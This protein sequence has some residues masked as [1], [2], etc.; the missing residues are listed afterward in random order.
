MTRTF[1]LLTGEYPPQSGGVGDYT[2]MVAAG[3][4]AR[5]HAVHV[6]SPSGG[7]PCDGVDVHRLPDAFGVRSRRMLGAALTSQPGT[8]LLQ[9]V[10]NALGV[11]G[12]NV[13][14]CAWLL[15]AR[16]RGVDVRVMFHEPY[17][18]FALRRPSRNLLAATQRVMAAL[19]LRASPVAYISTSAWVRYLRPWG[20][21]VLI[22]SPI[23]ATIPS[24]PV[25]A[26]VDRWRTMFMAGR[27]AARLV[28]HFGTFGD[29]MAAE[30]AAALP[31]VLAAAPDVSFVL[32]GR[33]AGGFAASLA[34]RHSA[35]ASRIVPADALPPGQVAAAL[36][37]CDLALQPYPDGVTTR[38]TSVMAPLANGVPVVTT[39]GA[40]TEPVW[41][42]TG[43]VSL[44]RAG[45]P[46]SAGSTV[47]SLLGDLAA[48]SDLG[49]RGRRA[50]HERFALR[51]TLEALLGAGVAA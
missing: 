1:H 26:D 7:D 8:L 40:L 3:L 48:R 43:A 49:L 25:R 22:E 20:A 21:R 30:L 11:R 27:G 50:Y 10:P 13:P 29:H 16:R 33:G 5:G 14:F 28:A 37:A 34:E 24:A 42:E 35:L 19:L 39:D 31:A 38:R 12:A 17:M 44:T 45:D 47:A 32:I 15:G 6:W 51:H 2:R 9:Y 18:Y 36:Q 23:P 46:V 4:A 41:R